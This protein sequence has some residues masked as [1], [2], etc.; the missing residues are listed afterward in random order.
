MID[1]THDSAALPRNRMLIAVIA[2]VGLLISLYLTL[3]KYGVIGTLACGVGSCDTVQSSPWAVFFGV[4]VPVIGLVG[5]ALLLGVA[6]FGLQPDRVNSRGVGMTLFLLADG[7]LIF[8]LYLTYLEAFVIHAWCRWCLASAA[9][10]ALIWIAT[11]PE[12][13]RLRRMA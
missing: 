2:L 12:L 6:L 3:H 7:A 11:L 4:P 9:L 10:I 5:Y 8:T 13:F 1:E